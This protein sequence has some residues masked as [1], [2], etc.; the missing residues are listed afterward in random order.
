MCQTFTC[1]LTDVQTDYR[2]QLST[3][4]TPTHPP[5][6]GKL[7]T[8]KNPSSIENIPCYRCYGQLVA[9]YSPTLKSNPSQP[10]HFSVCFFFTHSSSNYTSLTFYAVNFFA[11]Q[12]H[13]GLYIS[14]YSTSQG[15]AHINTTDN[16]ELTPVNKYDQY[17]GV[18]IVVKHI[19]IFFKTQSS[20]YSIKAL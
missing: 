7:H 2:P 6:K 3:S 19:V 10:M 20:F 13:F 17:W 1:R 14:H 18:L 12:C 5:H 11:F 4:K 15:R 8:S 9:F 16:T